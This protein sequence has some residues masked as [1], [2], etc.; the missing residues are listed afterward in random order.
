MIQ[1]NTRAAMIFAEY[2]EKLGRTDEQPN[3]DHYPPGLWSALWIDQ[4]KVLQCAQNYL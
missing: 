4:C 3:S 2:F 1:A